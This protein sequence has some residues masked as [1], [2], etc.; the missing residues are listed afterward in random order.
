MSELGT[1]QDYWNSRAAHYGEYDE[2]LV[3]GPQDLSFIR[4]HLVP[5]GDTLILGTTPAHCT[6][7]LEVSRTVTAV[8]FATD[9]IKALRNDNVRYV[10][11]EWNEF[12]EDTP[13]SYDSIVTD[14]GLNC[15]EFPG[16]WLRI[17]ENIRTLLKPN[18]IFAARVY[19]STPEPPKPS[20]ENP[21]L[22]RFVSGMSNVDQNWMMSLK[23]HDDYKSY[24]VRYAFPPEEEVLGVF[25]QV[26]RLMLVDKLA[27]DYE[28]GHRFVSY[29]WQKTV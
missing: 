20:Y 14:G 16:T 6:V 9:M 11:A 27:P 7:A 4:E 26:G 5:D 21:N 17:A 12:L 13:N 3:P 22:A 15:L 2:P 23:T 24:D 29:A 25:E 8:D 1:Q 10:C 19:I 18:G 28:E